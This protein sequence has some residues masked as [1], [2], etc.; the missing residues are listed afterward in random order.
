MDRFNGRQIIVTGAGSGIGAATVARLLDEGGTVVACDVSP[1]GLAATAT[2]ADDAGT[3]K[4]LTTTVLDVSD[5]GTVAEAVDAAV[6]EMGGLD[7][8]VNAAAIQ[9]CAHTHEHTLD[10]WNTT[11]AVNLTGTFLMTRRALPALLDSGRGVVVNFT[12][13][14]ASFA[15][16]YMAAYAASKGGVLAFTHSLAL[17]YSKQGLRAV[18]I[19]PGGVAT[20]LANATLDKM[21]DGYDLG[22]WAKQT[23]LLH[24]R[25]N[26][27]LGDPSSVASVIAM[28]AS[29]DGAFITG[30]EIRV[31]GGAHA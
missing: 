21:P 27:I 25:E 24:G 2:A 3:R 1:D 7:V 12:S 30:T 14:A 6:A 16:P 11:L 8:L 18:N 15:H 19:Q 4:R 31:D 22:L 5:E 28:V 17:E 13:T 26:E 23:P 20:A 10:D 9:R 29:D